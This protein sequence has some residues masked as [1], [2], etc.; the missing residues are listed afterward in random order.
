MNKIKVYLDTNTVQDFFINQALEFKGK[1]PFRMPKKLEFF[2]DNLDRI[3]F[4]T[5]FY[6][7][8][9]IM[10]EM[11]AGYGMNK[12]KVEDIWNELMGLLSCEFVT[13]FRFDQNLVEIAANL[14]LKLRTLINFQHLLIAM[15][16]S[17][18]LVTGD[19]DLIK[20]VRENKIY[21]KILSYI[22]LRKLIA[23]LF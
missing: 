7:K 3:D 16:R 2:I 15:D 22:E 20:K 14:N 8:A 21:D 1:K 5:S 19:R 10:R 6:T 4:I 13:E 9:E 18:Y 23:S 17:T 12:N 11:V